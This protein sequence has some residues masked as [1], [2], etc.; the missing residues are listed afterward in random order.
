M[1]LKL[2]CDQSFEV[3]SKT[4]YL[5]SGFQPGGRA[6]LGG[7]NKLLRGPQDYLGFKT[8]QNKFKLTKNPHI[9]RHHISYFNLCTQQLS[10]LM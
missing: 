1:T 3:M 7:H 6:P 9:S 5:L 4:L 8:R 2:N 10:F